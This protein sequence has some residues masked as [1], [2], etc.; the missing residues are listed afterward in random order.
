MITSDI[1][2][3]QKIEN[4][5]FDINIEDL[6]GTRYLRLLLY[7]KGTMT[8]SFDFAFYSPLFLIEPGDKISMRFDKNT[9]IFSGKN[10]AK[11]NCMI[12]IDNV[13]QKLK[14]THAERIDGYLNVLNYDLDYWKKFVKESL[15]IL[16]RYKSKISP[17]IFN[18]RKLDIQS[19]GP[20][21]LI[22]NIYVWQREFDS[23]EFIHANSNYFNFKPESDLVADRSSSY[24][25]FLIMKE[26]VL[27]RLNET[28]STRQNK[29]L[30]YDQIFNS[31]MQNYSGAIREKLLAMWTDPENSSFDSDL[32]RD[33]ALRV[34]KLKEYR[35]YI[36]KS[37]RLF[38]KGA[39]VFNFNLE[40]TKG[41]MVSL[42]DFRNRIV[43]LD[44]YFTGCSGCAFYAKA[45]KPVIREF[46]NNP[47]VV[48]ISI[49]VDNT[50]EMFL[51][52]VE[53]EVYSE[54]SA[55]NL[56]T[57]GLGR[58]HPLI[59]HYGFQGFPQFMLVDKDGKILYGNPP[60]PG[61]NSKTGKP[62]KESPSTKK[63]IEIIEEALKP[64]TS[65]S[66]SK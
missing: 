22:R 13:E 50:K 17:E 60:L 57:N 30:Y 31:I 29:V 8:R 32:Y 19:V 33:K 39:E 12:E 24:S 1:K 6:H 40:D 5:T 37:N 54:K 53:S 28:D 34:I 62:D 16:N 59:T 47:N 11:Y 20:S 4:R 21:A 49:N 43:V 42:S 38:K 55:I 2:V 18:I 51:K 65:S 46:E 63:I 41:K 27:A 3:G 23:K 64:E 44:F 14:A 35:D 48:F 26:R 52:A 36:L 45:I 58:N 9:A 56:F 10:S 15:L 61:M 7:S 25:Q 66:N